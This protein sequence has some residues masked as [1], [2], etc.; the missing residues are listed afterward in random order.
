MAGDIIYTKEI[1]TRSLPKSGAGRILNIS[2]FEDR[3]P[4][5]KGIYHVVIRSAKDYWI[6]DSRFI[7]FS[8]IG[9]IARQGQDKMFV[10]A[11]SLKTANGMPGVTINVYGN[12]NQLV[13]SAAT[14]AD[15]VAEVPITVR[16]YAGFKPAMVIAKTADD[17]T[18]LP[19][20]RTK[21]NTSRFDVGGKRNN[22]T[23]VEPR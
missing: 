9:L 16:N 6:R 13:G 22:S 5:I 23:G 12:N 19:F 15:G 1:D 3:L 18:Y 2:Q 14:N 11:N 17:F 10:F 21:V 4:D 20:S 7:S 8:D